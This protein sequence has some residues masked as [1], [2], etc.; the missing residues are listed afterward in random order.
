MTGNAGLV[1]VS[2]YP[3]LNRTV[4]PINS[5]WVEVSIRSTS[6]ISSITLAETRIAY[7]YSHDKPDQNRYMRTFQYWIPPEHG[8]DVAVEVRSPCNT[9][10]FIRDYGF[11][12]PQ[13]PG[14]T[15]NQR[16]EYC[17]PCARNFLSKN[18]TDTVLVTK[19]FVFDHQK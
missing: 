13:I 10:V 4:V 9:K 17:M 1:I 5:T 8:F 14:F 3:Q 18:R 7:D 2:G 12:L 15:Y 16:P 11:G 19:A 6:P